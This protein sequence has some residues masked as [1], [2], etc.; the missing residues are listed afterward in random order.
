[1]IHINLLP[2]ALIPK[3]R[4]VVPYV[5]VGAVAVVMVLWLITAQLSVRGER[6]RALVLR[7]ELQTELDSY[8]ETLRQVEL[9]VAEQDRLS[10]KETAIQEITAGRTVWSHELHELATLVPGQIWL[11]DMK[12]GERT[13][14]VPV[15]QPNPNTAAGQPLTITVMQSRSFPAV[16]LQGYA[17]SPYREEG[18]RLVGE[19]ITNIKE[20]PEF[21]VHFAD[22]EMR[23][24]ERRE[25]EDHTVMYFTMDVEIQ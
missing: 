20:D 6:K 15:Q 9:L 25:F 7:T 3:R 10:Q 11:N 5:G 16:M 23:T 24:I 17:L 21:A 12:L 14:T 22:P 4:N 18:V 19:F 2:D 8:A 13:R 1:M